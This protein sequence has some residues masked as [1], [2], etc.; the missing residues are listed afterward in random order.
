MTAT[1]EFRS[2]AS[3]FDEPLE[4]WLACHERVQRFCRLLERLRQHV[5][6]RGADR[7]AADS[8]A[9]IRRYFNEA[10]PRH[11]ADEE[12]DL[13]PRLLTRLAEETTEIDAAS[14]ARVR[15][16]IDTL[17]AEHRANEALWAAIDA[18]LALIE[19]GVAA[20]LDAGQVNTFGRTYDRHIHVEESIVKPAMLRHLSDAD[21]KDVGTVMAQRR[22]VMP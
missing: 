2:P 16:A 19:Q 6:E 12:L 3:G 7:E 1:I 20:R 8:A 4:L 15:S 11:H 21:W 18:T 9:S 13:F 10:A 14:A 5:D 22:G 17:T